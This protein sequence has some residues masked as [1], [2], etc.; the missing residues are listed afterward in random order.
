MAVR[1]LSPAA[2][3]Q[4]TGD[5]ESSPKTLRQ[6]RPGGSIFMRGAF[7]TGQTTRKS[8]SANSAARVSHYLRQSP[9]GNQVAYMHGVQFHGHAECGQSCACVAD[10]HL[11]SRKMEVHARPGGGD[12]ESRVEYLRMCRRM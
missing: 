8:L 12:P 2:V 3:V 4:T 7:Q 10:E 9:G 11:V 6:I 5:S 1:M